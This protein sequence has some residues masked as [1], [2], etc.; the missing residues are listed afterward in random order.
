MLPDAMDKN[1]RWCWR[2]TLARFLL[3]LNPD[4][5]LFAARTIVQFTCIFWF[6]CHHSFFSPCQCDTFC[7][8]PVPWHFCGFMT[9]VASLLRVVELTAVYLTCFSPT[10]PLLSAVCFC[11]FLQGIGSSGGRLLAEGDARECTGGGGQREENQADED[12]QRSEHRP[13]GA[14]WD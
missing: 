4:L 10:L 2:A 5:G 14:E 6:T 11:I 7:V 3:G 9:F 13:S 12:L 1:G 8:L